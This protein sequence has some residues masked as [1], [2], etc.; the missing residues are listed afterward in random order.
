MSISFGAVG[1]PA[2]RTRTAMLPAVVASTGVTL[3]GCAGGADEPPQAMTLKT[4]PAINGPRHMTTRRCTHTSLRGR[5]LLSVDADECHLRRDQGRS[6]ED[7]KKSVDLPAAENPE[8][9]K[10]RRDVGASAND[11]WADDIVGA[12]DD[13]GAVQEK[14]NGLAVCTVESQI[15]DDRQPHDGCAHRQKREECRCDAE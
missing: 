15:A 3:V 4:S 14:K 13:E 10:D 1:W 7:T 2:K 12:A 11:E 8:K 5:I 9:Q 6:Q